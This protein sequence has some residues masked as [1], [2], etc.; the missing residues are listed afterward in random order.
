MFPPPIKTC[1]CSKPFYENQD[2]ADALLPQIKTYFC[3]KEIRKDR[4][5]V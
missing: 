5:S 4:L 1:I 3:S 2:S